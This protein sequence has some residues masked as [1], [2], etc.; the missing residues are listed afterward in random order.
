MRK[1]ELVFSCLAILGSFI[2][3]LGLILLSIFDTERY[4][5][6]HRSFLLVFMVGVALS[7]IFTVVEYRWISHDF[8]EARKLKIAYIMKAIITG[9]LVILAIAFAVTLFRNTDVGAVLEWTIA[10]GFTFYILTF[11]YDLRQ[12]KGVHKGQY[13]RSRIR[14]GFDGDTQAMGERRITSIS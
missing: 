1:R 5:S 8:Y 6:A 9:V 7:A 3:G 2:G 4:T 10:F 14:A 13:K 11:F 12:A